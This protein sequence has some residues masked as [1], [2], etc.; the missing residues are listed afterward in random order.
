ML[1]VYD[2]YTVLILY[3]YAALSN[4]S[5][6]GQTDFLTPPA[7]LLLMLKG[8]AQAKIIKNR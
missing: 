7:R 6:T 5:A 4:T 8:Q 1:W 3:N 2:H